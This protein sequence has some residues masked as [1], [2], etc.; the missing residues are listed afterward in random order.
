[1]KILVAEDDF[2]IRYVLQ[3]MFQEFGECHTASNGLEALELFKMAFKEENKFDLL[4][5]D[6]MMPELTGLEVLKKIR[7]FEEEKGLIRFKE[8]SKAIIITALSDYENI[9]ESFRS[10]A[11]GYLVKPIK[12]ERVIEELKN[13]E[14]L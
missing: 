5:L 9:K 11:D 4:C 7:D 12:K 2:T 13:L 6:I 3:K 8:R 10:F 14:L 1:M